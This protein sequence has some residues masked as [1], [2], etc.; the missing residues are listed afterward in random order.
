VNDPLFLIHF[1]CPMNDGSAEQNRS[2]KSWLNFGREKNWLQNVGLN[3]RWLSDDR[4]EQR[5][6]QEWLNNE[7]LSAG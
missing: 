1:T 7:W 2:S 6:S 4:H 5:S 3:G